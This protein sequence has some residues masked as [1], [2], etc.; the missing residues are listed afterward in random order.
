MALTKGCLSGFLKKTTWW[1]GKKKL[2]LEQKLIV[3]LF[4]MEHIT[5]QDDKHLSNL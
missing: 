5:T 3:F 4:F 1:L 2:D